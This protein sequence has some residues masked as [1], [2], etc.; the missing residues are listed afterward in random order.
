[1]VLYPRRLRLL[2]D[3]RKD[4]IMIIEMAEIVVIAWL[5]VYCLRVEH[6]RSYVH[7]RGYSS[8]PASP[9]GTIIKNRRFLPGIDTLAAG[10]P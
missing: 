4:V 6:R 1:M 10:R 7:I 2:T 5:F 9:P 8:C 3:R